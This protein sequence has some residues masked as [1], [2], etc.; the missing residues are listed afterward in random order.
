MEKPRNHIP[1]FR[2]CPAHACHLFSAVDHIVCNKFTRA[3]S[4]LVIPD[5]ASTI[6]NE[7]DLV[8]LIRLN[9]ETS[10]LLG[11]NTDDS[12]Q[13]TK[14]LEQQPRSCK[15]GLFESTT[16]LYLDGPELDD[17]VNSKA[18]TKSCVS[19]HVQ[20]FNRSAAI[21]TDSMSNLLRCD[22]T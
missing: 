10:A 18:V 7:R 20:S 16:A 2:C 1:H 5:I 13:Q 17:Y 6:L 22:L 12:Q 8:C 4:H 9:L 3:L 21:L 14:R 19:A 11:A 15:I